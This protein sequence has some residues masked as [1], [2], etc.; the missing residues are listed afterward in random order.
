LQQKNIPRVKL[1]IYEDTG[2]KIIFKSII[3][4]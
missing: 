3:N 2:T 1:K 4:N